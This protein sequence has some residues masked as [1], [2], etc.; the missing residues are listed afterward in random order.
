MADLSSDACT[1][2]VGSGLP[3]NGLLQYHNV[4]PLGGSAT[5]LFAVD[6]QFLRDAAVSSQKRGGRHDRL[7]GHC[8][9]RRLSQYTALADAYQILG[10]VAQAPSALGRLEARPGKSDVSVAQ[11]YALRGDRE[12][13]FH[14]LDRA[15]DQHE[16]FMHLKADPW[17][18]SV[19]G[20]PRYKALL[21]KVNLPE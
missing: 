1:P 8:A 13:T 6:D 4:S 20:D 7:V 21:R 19:R 18:N 10:R 15:Y 12:R 5:E 11:I 9:D 17:F 3:R 16:Y 14:W 2:Q